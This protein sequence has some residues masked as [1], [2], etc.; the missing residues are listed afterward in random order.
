VTSLRFGTIIRDMCIQRSRFLLATLF[1]LLL[2]GWSRP[3]QT[4]AAEAAKPLQESSDAWRIIGPGG[5]GAQYIPTINPADPRHVFVRCDMTGSYVTEDGGQSWRMFNLRT[6]VRDFAFDP[7]RPDTVYACNSGLYRSDDRGRHWT[8]VYPD[9]AEIIEE[10][11]RGDH[12]DHR[13]RT[14]SGM[15]DASISKVRV[16]PADS[17]R[18]Y[19]GLTAA[20]RSGGASRLLRSRD[21][22]R[23]WET[24]AEIEGREVLAIFPG[25]WANRPEE[26]TVV[27]FTS[28]QANFS[29]AAPPFTPP[30]MLRGP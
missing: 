13:F 29:R 12:A 1:V 9:P 5:G 15:P 4:E 19:L 10:T 16:D 17:D 18:V 24:L 22:G 21:G 14:K 7:S 23:S 8:L 2:F 20:A 3:D 27:T 11:M 6:V 26:V 28:S 30:L 25:S